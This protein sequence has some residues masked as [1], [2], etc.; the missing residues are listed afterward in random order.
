M[1]HEVEHSAIADPNIHEPK[2]VST[3]TANQ[4]YVANGSGS[5]SWDDLEG[6]TVAST[7]EA[8]GN[9]F[10]R[11]DG[12]NTSS[13]NQVEGADLIST[14]PVASGKVPTA[15][16]AGAVA[17]KAHPQG[18]GFY[19]D[20]ATAQTFTTT[21]AKLSIN[22]G[23]ATTETT[24]LPEGVTNFWDTTADEILASGLGHSYNLRLDLP[25]SNVTGSASILQMELDIGGGASPSTVIVT[26][27]ISI[28]AGAAKTVSVSFG[29]F[30][31]AT[32]VANNGQIFLSTDAN[33]A[34]VTAPQILIQRV[35]IP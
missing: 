5:G 2:N 25:I 27:Q 22:G 31:L 29:F 11:E 6:T 7:G 26:R 32:F 24:Y 20:N 4:V 33:T 14:G 18:W 13:W 3:A 8:G 23:A 1:S 9:K 17:W 10:L 12:D 19:V 30:S 16:G 15:D 28:A 34:D 35:S 21:A